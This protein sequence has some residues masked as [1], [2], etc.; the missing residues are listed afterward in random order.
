MPEP[1]SFLDYVFGPVDY[2]VW[3]VVGGVMVLLLGT[4]F[5]AGVFVWTLPIET[6]RRIPV[7]RTIAYRVLQFKFSRSLGRIAHQH[8]AG[9]ID[10]REACHQIS[11]VFRLFVA[12]RTGS[13]VRGMTASDVALDSELASPALRVLE[14]TYP[15][16]FS[17][18]EPQVVSVAVAEA[19][20]VVAEWV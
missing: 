13:P 18:A 11:Q 16:Q 6:L 17:V 15:G 14:L 9:R 19:Q 12:F 8:E 20:K 1:H 5:V 7:I 2:P 4:G 10:T 3:W